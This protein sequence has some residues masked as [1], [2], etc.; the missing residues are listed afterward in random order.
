MN[1]LL[2][3]LLLLSITA[4]MAGCKLAVIVVEGGEVQSTGSG[5][6]VASAICIVDVVDPNFSETFTAVPNPGWRFVK[7]NKGGRMFCA[8]S[9]EL[10]CTLSLEGTA[11][12]EAIEKILASDN[13]FYLMPIFARGPESIMVDGREWAQVDLFTNLSWNQINAI[14]PMGVCA[15]TLN[16]HDMTGWTW[17]S[18]EDLNALFNHYVGIEALGPGPDHYM[19]GLILNGPPPSLETDGAIWIQALKMRWEA[20]YAVWPV[21]SMHILHHWWMTTRL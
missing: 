14:C 20:G 15:G 11:G 3:I 17:A 1:Q 16:G 13:T 10:T 12:N 8:D 7:W 2:R 21:N 9:T 18:V 5:T 4:L 6:C 19:E